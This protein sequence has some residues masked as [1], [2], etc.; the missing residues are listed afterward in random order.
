MKKLMLCW[1]MLVPL[2]LA[3]QQFGGGLTGGLV[4]SQVDGDGV[5]GFRKAGFSL[6]GFATYPL[7]DK[8]TLQPEI[9]VEQL[10]SSTPQFLVL[11]TTHVSVPMLVSFRLPILLGETEYPLDIQAGPVVGVLLGARDFI[12]ND[13]STSL[14][15]TD[16]RVQAGFAAH[17]SERVSLGVR[18]GYSAYSFVP[19]RSGLPPIWQ[20][21]G[22][23]GAYHNY[24]TFGLYWHVLDR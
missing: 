7:S 8:L 1:L 21:T 3:A 16:L 20:V 5:G 17:L 4:V 19:V 11:R 24:I 13:L 10:G 18:Y 22:Q 9:R 14:R 15:R 23:V 2:S 12:G 6:G